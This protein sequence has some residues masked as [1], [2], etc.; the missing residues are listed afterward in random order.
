MKYQIHDTGIEFTG[1][2]SVAEY[3]KLLAVVGST[4]TLGPWLLGDAV[5]YGEA[6][7]GE[8]YTQWL[9]IT[10][11]S[12]DR[13]RVCSWVANRYIRSRRDPRLSFEVHRELAFIKDDD[14][15]DQILGQAFA[16]GWGS[17]EVREWKR[18]E[19]GQA[20]NHTPLWR[21]TLELD[22]DFDGEAFIAE[23]QGLIGE[24]FPEIVDVKHS[25]PDGY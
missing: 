12:P 10:G 20:N 5:N 13:L 18:E 4:V 8:K 24:Y 2:M 15:Q 16:E 11:L 1:K 21:I 14:D 19:R 7:F 3:K 23:F 22:G 25:R 9:D 6:R 17:K